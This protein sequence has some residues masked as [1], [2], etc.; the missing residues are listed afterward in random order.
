VRA[1]ATQLG[2]DLLLS[3]VRGVVGR[4]HCCR[5]AVAR[6]GAEG[7]LERVDD[8]LSSDWELRLM[9]SDDDDDVR[10]LGGLLHAALVF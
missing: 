10:L 1:D 3:I 2:A 8:L 5:S 9:M 7:V 6:E 4:A